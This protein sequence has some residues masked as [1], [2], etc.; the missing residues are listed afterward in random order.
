MWRNS[1]FRH[2]KHP[3][4]F[5]PAM[6]STSWAGTI[7]C[8]RGGGGG[9]GGRGEGCRRQGRAFVGGRLLHGRLHALGFHVANGAR[10]GLKRRWRPQLQ[11]L[12]F[13]CPI[14][15]AVSVRNSSL[16]RYRSTLTSSFMATRDFRGVGRRGLPPSRER[17]LGVCQAPPDAGSDLQAAQ[18][19][20]H[21]LLKGFPILRNSKSLQIYAQKWAGLRAG[22]VFRVRRRRQA[23]GRHPGN[24][25]GKCRGSWCGFIFLSARVA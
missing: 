12:T 6:L 25:S 20:P 23:F 7:S 16:P 13:F 3:P 5:S 10:Q 2:L 14:S 22:P 1:V 18:T 19:R 15:T 21:Q 8:C 11:W 17:L 4:C 9:G 24:I